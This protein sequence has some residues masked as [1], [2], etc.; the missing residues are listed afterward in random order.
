MSKKQI[1]FTLIELL[2]VIA[3]IGILSGLIVISMN[4]TINSANDAR[5]KENIDVL[6]KALV[7]YG[8]DNRN[9]FPIQTTTCTIGDASGINKCP[10]SFGAAIQNYLT[11]LPTDPVSGYYTYYS[12]AGSDFTISAILSDSKMYSY[13]STARYYTSIIARSTLSPLYNKLNYIPLNQTTTVNIDDSANGALSG[14]VVKFSNGWTA[15]PIMNNAYGFSGGTYDVY[16][17]I[18]SDGTGNFP[19]SLSTAGVYNNTTSV[20]LIGGS[21]SGI[22]TSYKTIYIGRVTING[23]DSISAYFS[24]SEVTTN[25]Y[26]DYVEFKIVQ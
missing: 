6:R 14:Y 19:T 17:R 21:Y 20:G 3:V 12:P 25:Y 13:N 24:S 7:F 18:R 9:T 10:S 2:V 26:L 15:R 1:A 23:T 16:A 8:V 22:T 4:G 11:V 5:R